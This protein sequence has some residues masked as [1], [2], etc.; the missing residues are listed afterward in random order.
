MLTLKSQYYYP[1]IS[2]FSTLTVNN[3]ENSKLRFIIIFFFS[4]GKSRGIVKS[5]NEG[6]AKK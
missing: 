4:H 3:E 1:L 5:G 2:P 6:N